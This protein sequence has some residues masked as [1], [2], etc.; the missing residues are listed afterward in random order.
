M[1][2]ISEE[3][4]P[5]HVSIVMDGNGRWAKSRGLERWAGNRG[6]VLLWSIGS[7][8]RG[9]I[10]RLPRAE[11]PAGPAPD[12]SAWAFDRYSPLYSFASALLW[13]PD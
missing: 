9:A 11:S 3:R 4:L 12:Y 6:G 13:L 10:L 5:Y 2:E 8:R 1:S 7:G